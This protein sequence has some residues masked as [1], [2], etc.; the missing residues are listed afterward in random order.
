MKKKSYKSLLFIIII[1]S[2]MFFLSKQF[3]V[4]EYFFNNIVFLDK[5]SPSFSSANAFMDLEFMAKHSDLVIVGEV[6]SNGVVEHK[7]ID[8]SESEIEKDNRLGIKP[9]GYDVTH[10]KIKIKE[11]I[12]GR[13]KDDEI[14]ISQLGTSD[15]YAGETKVK[16]GKTMILLL[17]KHPN[18][19]I[20]YSSVNFNDGLYEV[21]DSGKI[22][23]LSEQV[24][25][26][27]YEDMEKK[28]F[29]KEVKKLRRYNIS[30]MTL[31]FILMLLAVYMIK[32]Y[33]FRKNKKLYRILPYGNILMASLI[34]MAEIMKLGIKGYSLSSNIDFFFHS[35]GRFLFYS[36]YIPC[37]IIGIVGP[38]LARNKGAKNTLP[39]E[40]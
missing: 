22:G 25:F 39:K 11:V 24:V 4:F 19:D 21:K 38:V 14:I 15:N 7:T 31:Y 27:K 20:L 26:K 36:V 3:P 32:K 40:Q 23:V 29:I 28:D 13:C 9:L 37:I 33:N 35:E 16:K 6:I 30:L 12:S 1:F 8:R 34:L 2:G 18:E 5:H 10:T 17:N